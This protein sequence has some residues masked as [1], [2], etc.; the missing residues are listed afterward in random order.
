M[1]VVLAQD[2]AVASSRSRGGRQAPVPEPGPGGPADRQSSGEVA[3]SVPDRLA[4]AQAA[5]AAAA[6]VPLSRLGDADLE[7]V[8][9][10]AAAVEAQAAAVRL[11]VLAEADARALAE[12]AAATGTEAWAARLTGTTRAVMAGG[13]WLARLLRERYAATRQA[14]A[15]GAINEAQARVIVKAAQTL[16]AGLTDAQRAAAEEGLLAKAVAGTGPRGL[17]QAARRMLETIS[18][19][20][21]DQH[22][23]DQLETEERRAEA[24]TYLRIWDNGDG[25]VS[26]RFTIPE[27]DGQ[28][29]RAAL[30]RLSAPRRWHRDR[31][32][33]VVEDETLLGGLGWCER[34]GQAFTEIIEH[35]PTTGHHPLAATLLVTIDH[36]HLRD[37][38]ASAGLDTGIAISAGQA[39]R[40]ACE[41][42][43]TPVVLAGPSQVLDRGRT[44]RLHTQAQ[45]ELL[46]LTHHSCAA[47]GCDRPFAWCE[48]HH[49]HAWADG[50]PTD[51]ANAVPLCGYHHR[52]AHDDRF[53]VLYQPDGTVRFRAR[54]SWAR[55]RRHANHT[56]EHT[57]TS[58]PPETT[59]PP[60]RSDPR[61]TA[62]AV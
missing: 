23:A 27:L 36:Q 61:A 2:L 57:G 22:E 47:A 35:L 8:L 7:R 11:A 40:L 28:M 10:C 48:I 60:R 25:T 15:D 56:P 62:P 5:L 54:R 19:Q 39:R 21:A 44:T 51:L 42:G 4:A 29:L 14:F 24:E 50:G 53:T 17:R 16:P 9:G 12:R 31:A 59:T 43:I 37:G 33:Q 45:R 34:L 46:A 32:G 38:L 52:R 6:G 55:T 1:G 30:E 3:E 13:L 26:G 49:P 58:F 20:L 18:A 41:A